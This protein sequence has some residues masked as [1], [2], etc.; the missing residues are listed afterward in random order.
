MRRLVIVTLFLALGC[1][2]Q[3]FSHFEVASIRVSPPREGLPPGAV[4][5]PNL[6]GGPGSQDPGQITYRD[7]G[8]GP[9]ITRAYGVRFDQISAPPGWAP[10]QRVDIIAKVPA[11]A[12][13][14]Q[15]DVMLQNLLAERFKLQ[16]HHES[17]I[18][19]VYVMTVAKSGLKMKES[20]KEPPAELAPG[21]SMGKADERGFPS[22]PPS[23]SG[24]VGT[25][26]D[27]RIRWTGQRA[28][29][30]RVAGLFNL[31]HPV[32]DQ[33]GLTGE[34]D[35]KVE[36]ANASR[37]PG[38]APIAPADAADPAPDAFS[39]AD[40]LGLKLELKRLPYDVL[41]IEHMEKEPTEN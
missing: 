3:D 36:I 27:G 30:S 2:A 17:R 18:L 33:T 40:Q 6:Q 16:L 4:P 37:R 14:E 32:L 26:T 5:A 7:I 8:L 29:M 19:P 12:T 38:A 34:Y 20:S 35:F 11:G 25:P 15:F 24:V 21:T 13:K 39:A 22:L 9:L 1:G 31:D 28:G 41:V 23:Y 10:G